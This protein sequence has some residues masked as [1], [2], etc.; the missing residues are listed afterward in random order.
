MIILDT[1]VVSEAIKP[2]CDVLVK[3]WLGRQRVETL[4]LTAT[5]LAELLLGME[6]LPAGRRKETLRSDLQEIFE[7]YFGSRIL[8]Y[9]EDAAI[10]YSSAVAKASRK[11]RAVSIADGQ[12]AAIAKVHGFTVATRDTGPFEAAGVAVV[13]PWVR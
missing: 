6:L 3:S 10:A 8:S 4:N 5:S 13:N 7:K 9:D 2:N 1:N 12:I 11:G